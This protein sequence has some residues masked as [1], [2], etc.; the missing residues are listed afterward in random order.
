M[1][2]DGDELLPDSCDNCFETGLHD[3]CAHT[4]EGMMEPQLCTIDL[5]GGRVRIDRHARA[6]FDEPYALGLLAGR[7]LGH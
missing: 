4:K 3:H 1:I 5:S 2:V 6:V 7:S